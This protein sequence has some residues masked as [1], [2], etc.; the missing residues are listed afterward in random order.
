M[1]KEIQNTPLAAVAVATYRQWLLHHNPKLTEA[2]LEDLMQ[3]WEENRERELQ[4]P[5]YAPDLRTDMVSPAPSKSPQSSLEVQVGRRDMTGCQAYPNQIRS[6]WPAQES[7]SGVTSGA[8]TSL[9]TTTSSSGGY[10]QGHVLERGS[11]A[12][13]SVPKIRSFGYGAASSSSWCT[14]GVS[15]HGNHESTSHM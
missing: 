11:V 2:Q 8:S 6:T 5:P 4:A 13:Q 15:I 14:N 12:I 3:H 9:V 7:S 10:Q 1:A